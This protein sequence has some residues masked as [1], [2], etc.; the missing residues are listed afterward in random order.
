MIKKYLEFI[1]E[2]QFYSDEPHGLSKY[3]KKHKNIANDII[4]NNNLKQNFDNIINEITNIN[5]TDIQL[6]YVYNLSGVAEINYIPTTLTVKVYNVLYTTDIQKQID[7]FNKL[8]NSLT[9][10]KPETIKLFILRSLFNHTDNCNFN[11]QITITIDKKYFNKF[12]WSVGKDVELAYILRGKGLGYK[13]VKKAILDNSY[14]HLMELTDNASNES[15]IKI[16]EDPDYYC[17]YHNDGKNLFV[18]LKSLGREKVKEIVTEFI[19]D[20]KDILY[21]SFLKEIMGI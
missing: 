12:D 10:N 3:N 4:I 19:K 15:L 16:A 17:L 11:T 8:L 7:E 20:K 18:I 6:K 1:N 21:D 2:D 13:V 14:L 9:I 5:Y